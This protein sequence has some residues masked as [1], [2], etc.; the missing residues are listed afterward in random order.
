MRISDWSSDVCSSDLGAMCVFLSSV[1]VVAVCY[2]L[3]AL[4]AGMPPMPS[5]VPR[6][7]SDSGAF[8]PSTGGIRPCRCAGTRALIRYSTSLPKRATWRSA[9]RSEEHTSELQS[10][11]R[12]SYA[13]FCLTK[14]NVM[15]KQYKHT[16][17]HH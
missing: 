13:V 8:R 15:N 6:D 12:I 10:L 9:G 1:W 14:K 2:L 17:Q 3:A 16:N 4:A 11:M 7:T 5:V